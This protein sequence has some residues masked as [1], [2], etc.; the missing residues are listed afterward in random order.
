MSEVVQVET[1]FREKGGVLIR[2]RSDVDSFLAS[3]GET[4]SS[5]SGVGVRIEEKSLIAALQALRHPQPEFFR[6]RL[7]GPG[8]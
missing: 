5:T 1:G 2:L 8:Y 6:K 7:K 4:P 3:C